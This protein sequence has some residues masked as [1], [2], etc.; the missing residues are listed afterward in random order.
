MIKILLAVDFSAASNY[1]CQYTDWL[2]LQLDS[3]LDVLYVNTNTHTEET[4]SEQRRRALVEREN[5]EYR[6]KLRQFTT[7]YPNR[8]PEATTRVIPSSYRVEN[9]RVAP[10]IVGLAEE[11]GSDVIIVGTRRK[12]S[13]LEQLFGSVS[14]QLIRQCKTP[15]LLVPEGTAYSEVKRIA[16]AVDISSQEKYILERVQKFADRLDAEVHPFFVNMLPEEQDKYKEEKLKKGE[17]AVTMVRERTV[18][19]GIDYFLHKYPSQMLAMYLPKRAFP[20]N[21]LSGRL[22]R[23]MA[24]QTPVPLLLVR[25]E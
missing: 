8:D 20:D 1:A 5:E 13:L 11:L 7:N 9:G 18:K 4:I 24:W 15:V 3:P 6:K 14:T 23:Q 16:L 12:H 10:T 19:E 17:E 22:S 2:C 21:W 25:E